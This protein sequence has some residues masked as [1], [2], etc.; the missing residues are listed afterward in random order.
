MSD[1]PRESG[2]D[3]LEL[4]AELERLRKINRALMSRVERSTDEVGSAF[5][6]F[7]HAILLEKQVKE[8]AAAQRQ[9]ESATQAK[10]SF[11]ANMSHEIRTPLNGII[12]I[13]QIVCES[14]LPS[15]LRG[16][17]ETVLESAESLLVLLNDILDFSKIEAGKLDLEIVPFNPRT[18]VE[19]VAELLSLSK[20]S[21]DIELIAR[22]D[23]S[24]PPLVLG[25]P[26]RLRQI[27]LNLVGNA[28]KFTTH[29]EVEIS[30]GEACAS[31]SRSVTRAW[32]SGRTSSTGSSSR[33]HRPTPRPPA[34]TGAPASASRSATSSAA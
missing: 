5:N 14:R 34:S 7:Q 8:R 4:K 20:T 24:V 29:G 27:L 15:G 3:V 16:D 25:D 30:V 28:V 1:S 12:G 13:L 18:L 26:S 21:R 9:A 32:A 10:S 31:S 6:M 2:E 23:P 11:L 19:D 22:V 17:L 33:S